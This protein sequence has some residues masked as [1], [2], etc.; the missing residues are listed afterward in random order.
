MDRGPVGETQEDEINKKEGELRK[1]CSHFVTFP[2]AHVCHFI[3]ASPTFSRQGIQR[4]IPT[5]CDLQL[6]IR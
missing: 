2:L 6:S 1:R 5:N 3:N 4:D